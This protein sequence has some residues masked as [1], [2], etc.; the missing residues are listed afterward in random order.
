MSNAIHIRLAV[1]EAKKLRKLISELGSSCSG[2]CRIAIKTTEPER[3]EVC[4]LSL[5]NRFVKISYNAWCSNVAHAVSYQLAKMFEI[6]KFGWE[7]IGWADDAKPLKAKPF[8]IECKYIK[9]EKTKKY[10]KALQRSYI[11]ASKDFFSLK[12]S[13]IYVDEP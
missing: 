1:G 11:K 7:C 9:D 3:W 8:L 4:S 12:E 6:E 2:F 10:F 5:S 13:I